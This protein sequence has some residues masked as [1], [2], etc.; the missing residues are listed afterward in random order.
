MLGSG[1]VGIYAAK[2]PV[3]RLLS[4]RGMTASGWDSQFT[5]KCGSYMENTVTGRVVPLAETK[6]GLPYLEDLEFDD[7]IPA[8]E[9]S[10]DIPEEEEEVDLS[11][12]E[13]QIID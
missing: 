7:N 13:L 1:V 11:N 12:I 2:L 6:T 9:V 10:I 3:E 5:K 4:A 8:H